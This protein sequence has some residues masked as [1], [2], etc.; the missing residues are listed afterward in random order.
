[1]TLHQGFTATSGTCDAHAIGARSVCSS[2]SGLDGCD[3]AF[4]IDPVE[5]V[6]DASFNAQPASPQA[7]TEVT[8]PAVWMGEP[9]VFSCQKAPG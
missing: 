9:S 8:S 1:M 7:S 2:R 4:S 5:L 6:I 3:R